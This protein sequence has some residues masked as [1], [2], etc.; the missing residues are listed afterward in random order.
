MKIIN[1]LNQESDR[2]LQFMYSNNSSHSDRELQVKDIENYLNEN[3]VKFDNFYTL[4]SSY[5]DGEYDYKLPKEDT[6]HVKGEA[7]QHFQTIFQAILTAAEKCLTF[8]ETKYN[9]KHSPNNFTD[10]TLGELKTAILRGKQDVNSCS[11]I[12]FLLKNLSTKVELSK[13]TLLNYSDRLLKIA[14]IVSLHELKHIH[15]KEYDFYQHL[16]ITKS[17][18]NDDEYTSPFNHFIF[19]TL[20]SNTSSFTQLKIFKHSDYQHIHIH[21]LIEAISSSFKTAF[22]Q[23]MKQHTRFSSE[24]SEHTTT[25]SL[26]Y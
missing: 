3:I 8:V 7:T 25:P 11:N 15:L 6:H 17:F 10:D 12:L 5:E 24:S 18:S 23:V 1:S 21:F 20:L 2:L 22:L 19:E 26:L 14:Y 4:L 9:F 16:H 13:K